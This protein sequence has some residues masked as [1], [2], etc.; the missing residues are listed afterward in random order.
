[1][2]KMIL[3]I[4]AASLLIAGCSSSGNGEEEHGQ[5]LIHINDSSEIKSRAVNNPSLEVDYY[6]LSGICPEGEP[7]EWPEFDEDEIHIIELLTGDWEFSVHGFDHLDEPVLKDSAEV[8]I[9]P[10]ETAQWHAELEPIH[11]YGDVT[12]DFVWPEDID[13]EDYTVTAEL[14]PLAGGTAEELSYSNGTA[15]A[16]EKRA[17][18]YQLH[19]SIAHTQGSVV[20]RNFCSLRVLADQHLDYSVTVPEDEMDLTGELEFFWDISFHDPLEVVIEGK[21]DTVLQGEELVISA[22]VASSVDD[23]HTVMYK[24][25]RGGMELNELADS[26]DYEFANNVTGIYHVSVIAY[27]LDDEDEVIQAGHKSFTYEILAE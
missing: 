16:S 1:M 19:I 6:Q 17:G 15:A 10:G 5:V 3:G 9:Y 11:G 7:Y 4:L 27:T 20:W 2:R 14:S 18:Y 22:D 25:F 8:S 26:M 24:L 13:E 23:E 21:T 12:L